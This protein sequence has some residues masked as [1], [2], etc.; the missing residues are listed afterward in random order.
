[1]EYIEKAFRDR[2]L[3]VAVL[4]MPNL[5]L[6]SLVRRQILEGVEAVVKLYR[7]SRISGKIPLQVFDRSGG[8]NNIRFE[9]TSTTTASNVNANTKHRIR[10]IRCSNCC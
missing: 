6:S 5:S 1:M 3:R 7:A 10:R 8:A 4:M 9:G 2:G